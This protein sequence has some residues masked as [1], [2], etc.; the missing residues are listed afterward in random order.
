MQS[1]RPLSVKAD[2]QAGTSEIE[3]E[4]VRFT[5]GSGHSGDI[6]VNDR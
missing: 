6:V 1:E 4:N 2:I 3:S 5:P